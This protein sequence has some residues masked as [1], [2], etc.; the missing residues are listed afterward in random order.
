ME[1][2]LLA[3]LKIP[4]MKSS[5][6][7]IHKTNTADNLSGVKVYLSHR[8]YFKSNNLEGW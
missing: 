1:L 2:V 5:I 4:L 8:C 6:S 3:C 7:V